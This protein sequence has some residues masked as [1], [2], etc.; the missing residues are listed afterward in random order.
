MVAPSPQA[1]LFSD[2]FALLRTY[3]VPISLEYTLDFYA[4]LQKGL[5]HNLDELFVFLRLTTVKHTE[6]LDAFERAFALY[7]F[8]I[9]IPAVAEGDPALLDTRQFQT[10]L[11]EAI[12]RKEITG[13]L[14]Q[15]NPDEL[16]KKFW[17]TLRAQLERHDGGTRWVGTGGASPFGHSGR[18]QPGVRVHGPGGGRS[19]IKA[20]GAR[21][22]IDYADANSLKGSNLRQALGALRQL[23]PSGAY[24]ALDIDA[25][26]AATARNGGEIELMFRQDLRDKI[27]V[28]LLIDNGGSSMLPHVDL[29][30]L[31]FEK[32]RDRFKELKTFYFHNSI[33]DWVFADARHTQRWPTEK[34][35][36][37]HPETRLI[38]IGDASMAPEELMGS[39]GSLYFEDES[40]TPSLEWLV[41]LRTRFKHSVWLNPLP[42]ESWS[43]DYGAW[44]LQQI[45]EVF[46]ME[47]LSLK[48]I[49]QAVDWLNRP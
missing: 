22:Y 43:S 41:R 13:P 42:R 33:Y 32:L 29:T 47:D 34:L 14:W 38:V 5:V 28:T 45:R 16:I 25:T 26:I 46:H 17:E 6:H 2:F 3:G 8:D 31:L 44:T 9:D 21:S 49:K 10:W 23:K 1:P 36:Q 39:R 20:I 11:R 18:P 4:G 35:L 40:V 12:E 37:Q 15:L 30:R 19:A 24:T 7:F 48:G 27:T